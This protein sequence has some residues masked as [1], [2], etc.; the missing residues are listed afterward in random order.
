MKKIWLVFL[1]IGQASLAQMTLGTYFTYQGELLLNGSPANGTYDFTVNLYDAQTGGTQQNGLNIPNVVV[2]NGL[3]NLQIDVGDLVFAGDERWFELT[4]SD[5]GGTNAVILQP[6]QLIT[7]APY[8]IHSQF[9]G[10][11]GVNTFAIQDGSVTTAKIAND[12]VISAK[13]AND[14]V[15]SAKIANDAVTSAKIATDAVT[16][17]KILDRTVVRT[18]IAFSTIAAENIMDSAIETAKIKDAAITTSK[19]QLGSVTSDKIAANTIISGDIASGAVNSIIIQDNSIAGAD[20]ADGSIQAVDVDTTQI[21]RRVGVSC[22]TGSSIRAIDQTGNVTCDSGGAPAWSLT[23]NSATDPTTNFIGTTDNKNFI[24]K[25]N[26]VET[27]RLIPTTNPAINSPNSI[28]SSTPGSSISPSFVGGSMILSGYDNTISVTSSATNMVLIGGSSNKILNTVGNTSDTSDSAILGGAVNKIQNS[29]A[30]IVLGGRDNTISENRSVIL[31]GFGNTVSALE[32]VALA[33]RYNV[34]SG[35]QSVAG[36]NASQVTHN[37]SFVWSDTSV[38]GQGAGMSTTADNQ[39]LIRAVGGV[40]IG[41]N[42][43]ASPLH[44][45]GLGKTFGSLANEVVMTIEPDAATADVSLAINRLGATKESALAFTTNK[46]PDFDIRSVNGQ[47]LDFNSYDASGVPTFMMRINDKATNRID[48]DANLEPQTSNS[49]NLGSSSYRWAT[50]YAQNPLD[51]PSDKRLKKDI[52]NMQYGLAEVLAMRPVTY[53]W[54]KGETQ[55]L[56]LGLIAQEVETIVPEIVQKANNQEQ[57]RSMRYSELIPVLIKATQE[58]Q[59][60]IEQQNSEIAELKDM[61]R[62]LINSQKLRNN[63]EN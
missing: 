3:F 35:T 53:H 43:P 62:S 7:N 41:T 5:Q 33:G 19:L 15:I 18:D 12:A 24:I 21:Q 58:Q 4:V 10:T 20:I 22:P 6:R 16:S 56:N 34:V 17:T 44:I 51:T 60:L 36:G 63:Y 29:G 42:I 47:A 25:A 26:N 52:K 54:K 61:V 23:G 45:K 46:A 38:T 32:S 13:I 50:I 2:S 37:G 8:A 28:I 48:F 40:G 11:D 59:S 49:V 1:L 57:T 14:A 31:G 39:F 9:V 27:M 55:R 30:S